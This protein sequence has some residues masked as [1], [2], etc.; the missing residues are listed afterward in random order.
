[1]KKTVLIL[2]PISLL[3]TIIGFIL[4]IES[5]NGYVLL[6]L[7]VTLLVFTLLGAIWKMLQEK[8]QGS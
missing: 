6:K 3:T 1:M 5:R 2:F 8:K 7:G 4:S